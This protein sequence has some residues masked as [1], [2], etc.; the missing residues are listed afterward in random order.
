MV[1]SAWAWIG[2]GF[3]DVYGRSTCRRIP[4]GESARWIGR[5]LQRRTECR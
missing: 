5:H 3:D 2:C 1:Q 4:L